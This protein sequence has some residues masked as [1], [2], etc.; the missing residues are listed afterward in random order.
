MTDAYKNAGMPDSPVVYSRSITSEY[1]LHNVN[2]EFETGY[3]LMLECINETPY[4]TAVIAI[5]DMVAYGCMN[6]VRDR[7]FRI[8]DDYS[9]CGFD[10]IF[11]SKFCGINLTT[12]EHHIIERG[13]KSHRTYRRTPRKPLGRFRRCKDRI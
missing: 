2:V 13:K 4:V 12:V 8:P 11:P 5:N 7:G 10:N 6:A 3:G 9:I 1:E